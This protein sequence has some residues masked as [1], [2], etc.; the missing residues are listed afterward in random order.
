[1]RVMNAE[2]SD[3]WNQ[4]YELYETNT[5]ICSLASKIRLT[6]KGRMWTAAVLEVNVRHDSIDGNM[7]LN[8]ALYLIFT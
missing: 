8:Q 6:G 7:M 5:G 4:L 2:Q 3:V 1:M